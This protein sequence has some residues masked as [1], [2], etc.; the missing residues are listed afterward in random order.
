[1]WPTGGL[2]RHPD[3]LRLWSA[4]T[5]SQFG[6]QISGLALPLV[7]I[8]LLDAS[9]FEVAALGVVEFLPFILCIWRIKTISDGQQLVGL[10]AADA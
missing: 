8:L 4:Q 6:S 10:A 9:A 3:F 5:I 7:A 1:M 2:W